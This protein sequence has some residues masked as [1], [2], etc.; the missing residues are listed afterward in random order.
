MNPLT[1]TVEQ[2]MRGFDRAPEQ[3]AAELGRLMDT[4]PDAQ[5]E[6]AQAVIELLD[7]P[8]VDW[9]TGLT[10]LGDS[11]SPRARELLERAWNS[12]NS[13]QISEGARDGLAVALSQLGSRLL[14]DPLL[15]HA[16]TAV[17][18]RPRGA[19]WRLVG[20][21]AKL[22]SAAALDLAVELVLSDPRYAL[23][24][25]T[26]R[27]EPLLLRLADGGADLPGALVTRIRSDKRLTRNIWNEYIT[28]L[29]AR[30]NGQAP[31]PVV[32]PV[33]NLVPSSDGDALS[34]GDG[35]R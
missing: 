30:M 13:G 31:G 17:V 5:A 24:S 8:G 26:T 4:S 32:G 27:F 20:S 12:P 15:T 6:V 23:A 11:G 14:R 1:D 7:N 16:S 25:P 35:G 3:F 10:V 29:T 19:A 33:R 34:N 21:L 9:Q 18:R 28:S 22:D 2:L